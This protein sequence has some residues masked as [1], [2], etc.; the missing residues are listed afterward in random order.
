MRIKSSVFETICLSICVLLVMSYVILTLRPATP[1]N[2][3]ILPSKVR[4]VLKDDDAPP[5]LP[6]TMSYASVGSALTMA[7]NKYPSRYALL[8]N[9]TTFMPS[10]K[11]SWLDFK[12]QADSAALD[13]TRDPRELLLEYPAFDTQERKLV[14]LRTSITATSN[15]FDTP[16][17]VVA[18]PIVVSHLT[19]DGSP[20][21]G[22][23]LMPIN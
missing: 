20:S 18:D 4:Q 11:V 7:H 15:T 1:I 10:P 6:V 12:V 21:E 13:V 5:I 16:T 8:R 23:F 22:V 3:L 2:E 9:Y 19:S 17:L 14:M